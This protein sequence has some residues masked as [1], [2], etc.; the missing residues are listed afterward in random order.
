M[1]RLLFGWIVLKFVRTLSSPD[2]PFKIQ[3]SLFMCM[4]VSPICA[5]VINRAL[6]CLNLN[7]CRVN[8][9]TPPQKKESVVTIYTLPHL[10]CIRLV[11][12][13]SSLPCIFIGV[14]IKQKKKHFKIKKISV[15]M[16][17]GHFNEILV[18]FCLQLR[19]WQR[20]ELRCRPW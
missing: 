7:A 19:V 1:N 9:N 3:S 20:S 4:K 17:C 2:G 12:V 13:F 15:V 16:L 10:K 11:S 5:L 6:K 18:L 8:S 14:Q